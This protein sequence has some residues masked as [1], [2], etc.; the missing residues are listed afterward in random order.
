MRIQ[1]FAAV[2]FILIG[3]VLFQA[4][5]D[6]RATRGR[7]NTGAPGGQMGGGGN[8]INCTNCHSNANFEVGLS[9][10][11][12]DAENNIVTEYV[13]NQEYTARVTIETLSGTPTG[14]GFQM[15]S[16]LESNDADVNGWIDDMHSD[17]VQLTTINGLNRRYAEHNGLSSS[18][19]FSAQW[20]APAASSG[21]VIF[22]IAGLGS[23]SNNGSGGDHAPEPIQ[24]SF[25]ESTTTSTSDENNELNIQLYPNPAINQIQISG[26]LPS[27]VS[28]FSN[29]GNEMRHQIL[30]D[31]STDTY[32]IDV[33][34]LDAGIYFLRMDSIDGTSVRQFIKL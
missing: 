13:P 29:Q 10:E 27:Q 4:H 5:A 26:H 15:V 32:S 23:N 20:I 30:S 33:T 34:N 24:V 25:P 21:D 2:A 9:L 18:N 14:W 6:G 22:Y 17:N 16:L 12:L 3:F 11:L 1:H 19:E 31:G 28:I 8:T 7:D